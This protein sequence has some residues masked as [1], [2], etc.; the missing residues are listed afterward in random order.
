MENNYNEFKT[1]KV[2]ELMKIAELSSCRDTA[3]MI[4]KWIKENP[5]FSRDIIEINRKIMFGSSER[6]VVGDFYFIKQA[7]MDIANRIVNDLYTFKIEKTKVD[8]LENQEAFMVRASLLFL[9]N[10]W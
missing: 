5:F 3:R 1:K 8:Y 10:E 9:C 2:N 4:N 6:D 7:K